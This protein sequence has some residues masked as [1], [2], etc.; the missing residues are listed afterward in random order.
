MNGENFQIYSVQ[1][2]G[3]A[4]VTFFPPL[5]DLIIRPHVK[6]PTALPPYNIAQK[7]LFAPCIAYLRKKA[8][9]TLGVGGQG[10]QCFIFIS[11]PISKSFIPNFNYKIINLKAFNLVISLSLISNKALN[12]FSAICSEINTISNTNIILL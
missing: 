12:L 1:I 4:F 6:Q 8:P 2:T 11:F 7:T 3:N 5:H 10:T 9:H